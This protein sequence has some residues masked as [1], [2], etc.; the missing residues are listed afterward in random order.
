M[1][2]TNGAGHESSGALLSFRD[3]YTTSQQFARLYREGMALVEETAEYL[4]REGRFESKQLSP[5]VSLAYSSESIK[6]TTRLTQIASWLLVRRAIASGEITAAEAHS[7]RH[8]ATLMAQSATQPEGF[9]TLPET[10]KRLIADS[11][12]LYERILRLDRLYSEGYS[13]IEECASP[14]SPH[15]ERIKLAFPAA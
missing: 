7:H 5:P 3:R 11:Q 12:R 13:A 4:D 10:F 15:I 14:I 8:R 1:K 6:L 2:S 9:D